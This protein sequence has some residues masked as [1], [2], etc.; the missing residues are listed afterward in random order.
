MLESNYRV[1]RKHRPEGVK[2]LG[3]ERKEHEMKRRNPYKKDMPHRLYVFFSQ[4][5]DERGAPS[6]IK[7]A[8]SIG[9]TLRDLEEYRK[10]GEFERAYQ[11]CI[12]IR[13]DYLTDRALTKRFD[14]SFVKYLLSDDE[15]NGVENDGIDLTLRVVDEG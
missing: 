4:Y 11:E 2:P 3:N 5:Q 9:V 8:R 13:R 14:P 15:E 12:E 1:S 6:F 10:H 7:F